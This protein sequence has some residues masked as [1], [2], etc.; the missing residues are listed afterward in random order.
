MKHSPPLASMVDTSADC[1]PNIHFPFHLLID[2]YFFLGSNANNTLP[3]FTALKCSQQYRNRS[4]LTALIGDYLIVVQKVD[5]SIFALLPS[6][7]CY[8]V[9]MIVGAPATILDHEANF[10]WEAIYKSLWNRS[11]EWA[12]VLRVN[13]E[14]PIQ[15]VNC[16]S[17][18]YSV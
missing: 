8:N 15:P 1:L 9:D 5:T 11:P 7:I 12:R 17:P 10:T 4:C 13:M 14:Q 6:S 2:S 3:S 18:I 16:L